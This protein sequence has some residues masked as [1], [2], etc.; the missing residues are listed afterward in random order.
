[1]PDIDTLLDQHV[2]LAYDQVDR[3]FL[4]GY[5]Q[6]LQEPHQLGWFLCQHRGEEIPRYEIL[7]RMTRDF[8]A[9][10]EKMAAEDAIPVVEF[11]KGQRKEDMAWPYQSELLTQGKEG[12]AMIGVAQEKA[13][14]FR[15]PAKSKRVVGK[16]AASRNSAFVKHFYVYVVDREWGPGFIKFCTYAPFSVRVC[17]NGHKWLIQRLRLRGHLVEELDNG[18]SWVDDPA[19]LQRLCRRFALASPAHIQRFFERWLHRLPNPFTAADRRAGYTY[20]LSTLQLEVSRTE[21]FDRPLHGRQ[22]FEQVILQQIDL[23]RPEKIQVIFNRRPSRRRGQQ[24]ARVRVFTQEVDPSLQVSRRNTRVKQYWKCDRALRTETTFNDTY[25]F[26]IGRSLKNL[27]QLIERG[28]DINYR[29]L[30]MERQSQRCT[31]AASVFEQ[32]V[33]PTGEPG[34]R[35][36]GLRFGDPRT[37]ALFGALSQFNLNV[38]GGFYAK[39]LRP[40]VEHHLA[41]PYSITQMGYDLGRL[42]KKGLLERLPRTNRYRL[43][44]LG[45]Q[46]T[47]FVTQVYNRLFC[48][49]LAQLDSGSPDTA[50]R[51][52]WAN[53][54]RQLQMLS[55]EASL[56]A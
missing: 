41:R 53:F 46:L 50:L 44:A 15:P 47:L 14:C 3:I 20:Q 32:L 33:M 56:A 40:I 5:V 37:V 17:L 16:F 26:N 21:V 35:A 45:R 25:D 23:G 39:Q 48:R 30:W 6:K 29:L 9:A 31:P 4:N 38:F 1:M 28:R 54:D 12:V 11:K 34:R 42:I 22:F 8:V 7:G 18:I 2:V 49:S 52:A 55:Q 19:A 10:M 43:T 13:N 27:P 36:P 51:R 24:P